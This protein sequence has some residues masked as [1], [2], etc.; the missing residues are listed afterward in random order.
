MNET[1]GATS[2]QF[3]VDRGGTFTDIVAR[4]P[5]GGQAGLPQPDGIATAA[6]APVSLSNHKAIVGF[7]QDLEPGFRCFTQR[8]AI[9]QQT[10]RRLVRPP[11]P[12][13]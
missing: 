12:A 8:C 11:D 5:D 4:R 13:A 2:W 10:R 9:E 1:G 7:A 3:W 6:Q